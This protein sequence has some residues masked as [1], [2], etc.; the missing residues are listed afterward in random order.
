MS[1]YPFVPDG[2]VLLFLP[3][4]TLSLGDVVLTEYKGVQL[5]HRVVALSPDGVTTWGDWNHFPDPP[6]PYSAVSGRCSMMLRKGIPV[7]I[8]LPAMRLLGRG[9]ALLLPKLK[10]L[11]RRT[12]S[13]HAP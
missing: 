6:V 9:L 12:A 8:D 5:A 1:M 13:R 10:S 11:R 3:A 2:A 7:D 4:E